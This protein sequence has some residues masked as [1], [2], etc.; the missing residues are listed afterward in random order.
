MLR[1]AQ[2]AK[3]IAWGL[4]RAVAGLMS[5]VAGLGATVLGAWWI[6]THVGIGWAIAFVVVGWTIPAAVGY[7]F[8]LL[9]G[10]V[11]A[12]PVAALFGAP[13]D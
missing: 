1:S 4:V 11:L 13:E 5:I 6:G 9:L 3:G 7:Y 12:V 8:G 10:M 2:T